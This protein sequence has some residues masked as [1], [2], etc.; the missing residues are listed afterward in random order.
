MDAVKHTLKILHLEDLASDAKLIERELNKALPPFEK[1]VVSTRIDFIKALEEFAPDIILSDHSLPSFDSVQALQLV[2]EKGLQI[3][4]ILITSAMTDEFAASVMRA[5]TSDYIIKDRLQRLPSAVLNSLEK[6]RLEKEKQQFLT[7]I[8]K[9]EKRF[10]TLIEKSKDMI[11][12]TSSEGQILYASPSVTKLFGYTP[13]EIPTAVTSN[14]IHP[15][16]VKL[17]LEKRTQI[18]KIPNGSVS[19]ELRLRHKAGRW[20]WCEINLTNLLNEPGIESMV[21]NFRDISD[22]KTLEQEKEFDRNNLN[23][24]IN[25]TD[26][27]MW[28][29]DNQYNLL[30]FNLPFRDSI[31]NLSGN[32]P[33]KGTDIFTLGFLEEESNRLKK[34]LERA[35]TGETFTETIF[36]TKPVEGWNEISYYP[37]RQGSG[38]IGIACYSRNISERKKSEAERETMVLELIQR[39]KSLEQFAYIVSHNLRSPIANILGISN[40]LKSDIS[41]SD[42][43][44]S[45]AYLFEAIAKLDEI[46]K[47]LN[48]ILE[49]K[50]EL[51]G[52]KQSVS[53]SEIISSIESSIQNLLKDNTVQLITD[54][55]AID[56]IES[57]KVYIYSIFLNLVSNSIKYK[58]RHPPVVID[59][60]S[61]LHNN[62]VR[63]IYKDN[64]IGI[65]LKKHGEKLFGL[66]KRFHSEIE[67][68][69]LG[70]FMVKTQ[71]ETLG[72]KIEAESEPNKGITF[73]IDL[74]L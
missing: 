24:L 2:K 37:I 59:I 4:F 15:D 31:L 30:T 22:K 68:K 48:S 46:I 20:I 57:I 74:P 41:E 66:Y 72:G 42:R 26:D 71:I 8:A 43:D 49:L 50:F 44:K 45:L 60:R 61:E 33:T 58:Q 27:L 11:T 28:S 51:T 52:Q 70:L 16:D 56:T 36:I 6:F 7:Q 67:G 73:T 21:A 12:L 65:D 29:V 23:A 54:F 38:I 19:Y 64:G 34:S 39:S 17:Y 63:I 62:K 47:D 3:P 40:I 10:R 9:N 32:I 35:L 5:G 55:K 14:F 18:Q 53:F 69:G 1:R 25:N 13:E